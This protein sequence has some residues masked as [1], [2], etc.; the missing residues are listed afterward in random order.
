[1]QLRSWQVITFL[2]AVSTL[3]VGI[4]LPAGARFGT[5]GLSLACGVSALALMAAAAVLGARWTGVEVAF[6]GLDRVYLAHKWLGIWALGLASVHL[7]FKAGVPEWQTAAILELPKGWPRLLRQLSFLGLMF[8]VLLALNRN[9]A[10]GTWRW[11]HK[12]SGPLF[13]V[14]VL[15]WLSFKQPLPLA[16]PVGAWLLA[17]SALGI[18]GAAWKLLLYPLLTRSAEYRVVSITPG[19]AAIHME[20]EPVKAGIDF[21]PG[22][23]GFLR[24]N[25]QGLR[26]PHPF[27]IATGKRGDGRVEF[28]IRALGDYTN[29]LVADARVGMHAQ[30]QAPFGRFA[31]HAGARREIWIGGGVGISPFIAWLKDQ[32]TGPLHSVTLFYF[33]T[34]GR[35]FPELEVMRAMAAARGAELVGVPGGGADPA[36]VERFA[37]ICREGDP[38]GIDIAF[39][40]PKGLAP[41]IREQMRA[42]GV[43]DA[44]L[45]YELFEFR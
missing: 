4:E 37:A 24:M 33:Y 31:R 15:H 18:A 17:L 11:W 44:N 1:M 16:S 36:F 22:Q 30:I 35:D 45:R 34:P 26:E 29:R 14:V 41:K 5:A 23:F 12:L 39:C 40:G 6:G 7:L 19:A 9:I 28:V 42:N 32:A 27:T 38:A 21:H 8:I 2:V 43:P 25:A 10:Y 20:L 3:L 13:V